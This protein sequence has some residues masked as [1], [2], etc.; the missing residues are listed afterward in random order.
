MSSRRKWN[1]KCSQTPAPVPPPGLDF[2]SPG[3]FQVKDALLRF[4]NA[5]RLK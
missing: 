2:G 4:A 5:V 3:P 1:G